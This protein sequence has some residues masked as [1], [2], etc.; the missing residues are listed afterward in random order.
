M[1]KG[2]E[3]AYKWNSTGAWERQAEAI[4]AAIAEAKRARTVECVRVTYVLLNAVPSCDGRCTCPCHAHIYPNLCSSI[5]ALNAPPASAYPFG[6][7]CW[8]RLGEGGAWHRITTGGY[9]CGFQ[10]DAKHCE[11]CG[12]PRTK[13]S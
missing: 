12:A 11:V 3:I 9:T 4:D 6:C 5:S 8:T 7:K 2:Q 1:T 10:L 13:G